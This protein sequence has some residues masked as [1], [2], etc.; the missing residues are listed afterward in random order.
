MKK[1][2]NSKGISRVFEKMVGLMFPYSQI[3]AGMFI[4]LSIKF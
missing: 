3:K 1:V 2:R 4:P